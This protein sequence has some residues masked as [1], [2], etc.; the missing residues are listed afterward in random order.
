MSPHGVITHKLYLF[1]GIITLYARKIKTDFMN[2]T[3]TFVPQKKVSKTMFRLWSFV[4]K[5]EKRPILS[6]SQAIRCVHVKN[7]A[8]DTFGVGNKYSSMDSAKSKINLD[9]IKNRHVAPRSESM[10][11]PKFDKKKT[12][13][14]GKN[15][16]QQTPW[17]NT[18]NAKT[19]YDQIK[20]TSKLDESDTFG[21]ITNEFKDVLV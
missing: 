1:I 11:S 6:F 15:K 7:S 14:N 9:A 13:F 16:Q 21:T 20:E 8:E 2:F 19:T 17:K 18:D 10:D 4:L 12:G 5:T 3:L